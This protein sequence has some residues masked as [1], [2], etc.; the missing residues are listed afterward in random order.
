MCNNTYFSHVDFSS[1][2]FWPLDL[3]SNF[4][5]DLHMST[6]AHIPSTY[7]PMPLAEETRGHQ[8]FNLL[9]LS[10]PNCSTFSP[11]IFRSYF[12]IRVLTKMTHF[13]SDLWTKNIELRSTLIMT[14]ERSFQELCIHIFSFFFF[15]YNNWRDNDQYVDQHHNWE[16]WTHLT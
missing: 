13:T 11:N 5:I 6:L 7:I 12:G 14:I 15:S 3:R 1:F 9:Y 8:R 4:E 2:L 16:I 10:S